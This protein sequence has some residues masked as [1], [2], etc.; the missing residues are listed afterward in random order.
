ML[1]ALTSDWVILGGPTQ[2]ILRRDSLQNAYAM[3]A[4]KTRGKHMDKGQWYKLVDDL[5]ITENQKTEI[6]KITPQSYIGEAVKL[7]ELGIEEIKN[8][9]K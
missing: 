7:V 6:K 1:D 4:S 8:S 5:P 2:T 9:R 3:L